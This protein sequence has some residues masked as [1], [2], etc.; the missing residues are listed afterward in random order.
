MD[1]WRH[2]AP[3][4][5]L[6]YPL[7]VSSTAVVH[8]YIGMP[9]CCH[10]CMPNFTGRVF[11]N[12]DDRSTTIK[13]QSSS[14]PWAP[15]KLQLSVESRYPDWYSRYLRLFPDHMCTTVDAG[16]SWSWTIHGLDCLSWAFRVPWLPVA[17]PIDWICNYRPV[18]IVIRQDGA[19]LG[20]FTMQRR[21]H[22]VHVNHTSG[23]LWPT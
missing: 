20:R 15:G 7:V 6:F 21:Q 8:T 4:T 18:S 12:M 9:V 22:C 19:E 23:V 5:L 1:I 3:S 16:A 2:T 11:L 14:A 17:V 13:V 10:W